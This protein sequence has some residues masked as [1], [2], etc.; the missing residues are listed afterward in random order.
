MAADCGEIMAP[1]GSG[2]TAVCAV[3]EGSHGRGCLG[4][5]CMYVRITSVCPYNQRVCPYNQRVSV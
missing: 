4:Y 1:Y 3:A 5:I 2:G